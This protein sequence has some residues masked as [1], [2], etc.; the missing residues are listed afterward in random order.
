MPKLLNWCKSYWLL[1]ATCFLLAFI[2]LYPK[3]PLFDI[4]QTWV[5]IRIEDFLVAI[6]LGGL[7]VDII[8]TKKK[9][10]TPLTKPLVA[11]WAVG[12]VATLCAVLFLRNAILNFFPHL[13]LL[14][15]MRRIEYMGLYFVGFYALAKKPK[16]LPWVIGTLA[17]TLCIVIIYGVG[18]KFLGWPAFLTMNEEFSKGL[19]LRLPPTARIP[20]TF[21]GHYDLAA[22]L[23]FMIPLFGSLAI[24]VKRVWQK[25]TMGLLAAGGLVLLLFT[26]SRISFG[27]YLISITTMLIWKKKYWLIVPVVIAS[28]IL[29]NS[30]S[31]ASER[32]YKTLRFSDVVI[33]LSTGQPVGTLDQLENGKATINKKENPATEN[34]PKGSEFLSVPPVSTVAAPTKTFKTIEYYTSSPL[35]TGSGEIATVSGSFLVQKAFVYDISITTRFQGEWPLAMEAFRRNMF[36]GSGFSSL[37]VATDGDYMRM[38]GE[39]GIIG[40]IMF[41]GIFLVAFIVYFRHVGALGVLEESYA[42]GVFAGL[43]GLFLNAILIDVFEAS[44]VAFSL[45]LIL[46]SA[47]ALLWQRPFK[48][49]YANVLWQAFT[50]RIAWYIYIIIGVF[51]LYRRALTLY[52]I[53]DDFTWLRW[54]ASTTMKDLPIFFVNAAGFFYRPIPKIVYFLLYTVFWLK[55]GAYHVVSVGLFALICVLLFTLVSRLRVRKWIA[56]AITALFASLSIH[57]ENVVWISGLS[58]LLSAVFLLTALIFL[59]IWK[60]S[61]GVKRQIW[62]FLILISTMASAFSHEGGSVTWMIVLLSGIAESQCGWWQGITLLLSG[63]VYFWLRSTSHAVASSGDYGIR[64]S[65]LVG[66]VMG[67]TLGYI[68]TILFGPKALEYM[69]SMRSILKTHVMAVSVGGFAFLGAGAWVARRYTTHIHADTRRI[70]VWVAALGISLVPFI[71]L[72]GL[73]ERYGMAASLMLC[74]ILALLMEMYWNNVSSKVRIVMLTVLIVCMVWNVSELTRVIGD[75]VN[76]STITETSV[77][78]L[79]TAYFPLQN[80]R[81]FVFVDTPIRR[82]RAWV[83]PTGLDDALWHMFKFNPYRYRVFTAPTVKEAFLIPTAPDVPEVLVFD[84]NGVLTKAHK[85]VQ[86]IEVGSGK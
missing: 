54:A 9:L 42:T 57:H 39:T 26:A 68:V 45:W 33:D 79:K 41:L 66:N 46:G 56:L 18:Q 8:I 47:T 25:L 63:I 59:L 12:A 38:L 22:Y 65:A 76:A 21:A 5:Y 55:S 2:P 71:G 67:N 85:E 40:T 1:T 7:F 64:M 3:L 13:A 72:G 23:V 62:W 19:P 14:H 78:T 86:T 81:A 84:K 83:F 28:F 52:F 43:V 20:S 73:A 80:T 31:T 10:D 82:G 36:L 24:G 44:K 75:W 30:V 69:G 70:L 34:L 58:S 15:F 50:H 49:S 53:G 51:A 4:V 29:L 17:L 37:S 60:K 35:A 11:Y 74:V 77:L 6:V 27:V 16:L 32:F 48:L 61:H